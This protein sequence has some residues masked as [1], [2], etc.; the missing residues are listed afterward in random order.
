V[1]YLAL[2]VVALGPFALAS[3]FVTLRLWSWF[4]DPALR[5]TPTYPQLYAAF[6]LIGL[7]RTARYVQDGRF[8]WKDALTG[9]L[10]TPTLLLLA[11]YIIRLGIHR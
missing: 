11:G 9:S 10:L 5:F 3:A 7:F 6:A 2:T 1:V 4:L 8:R